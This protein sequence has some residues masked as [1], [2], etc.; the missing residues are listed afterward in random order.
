MY[1]QIYN[2]YNTKVVSTFFSFLPLLHLW[3][4]IHGTQMASHYLVELGMRNMLNY[5]LSVQILSLYWAGGKTKLRREHSADD[6]T[7]DGV[8]QKDRS[9]E[10]HWDCRHRS[11]VSQLVLYHAVEHQPSATAAWPACAGDRASRRRSRRHRTTFRGGNAINRTAGMYGRRSSRVL[12]TWYLRP[13]S[14]WK[15]PRLQTNPVHCHAYTSRT[16]R[17]HAASRLQP[18]HVSCNDNFGNINDKL[19][20]MF[21]IH[22]HLYRKLIT[23][24]AV[25]QVSK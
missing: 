20:I 1:C 16:D 15:Q 22:A 4:E 18:F 17:P 21:I 13:R 14:D 11:P 23:S 19:F 12:R 6:Q 9:S 8:Q 5:E 24:S 3:L 10:K 25:L 2:I 7:P